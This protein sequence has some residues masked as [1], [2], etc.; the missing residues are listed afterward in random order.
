M[1][2]GAE[3]NRSPVHSRQGLNGP[4][5][6]LVIGLVWFLFAMFALA[7]R[8]PSPLWAPVY[9]W[10]FFQALLL[11]KTPVGFPAATANA[12]WLAVYAI[13]GMGA[14]FIVERARRQPHEHLWRR[15]ALSWLAIQAAICLL[16]TLLV[17][18]GLLYE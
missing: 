14:W 4:T 12:T 17:R 8:V 1:D 11:E 6:Y 10:V 15:A 7:V 2:T 5:P 16:L 18:V 9:Y 3:A 13:L